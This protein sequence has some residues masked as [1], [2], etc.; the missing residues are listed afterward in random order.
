MN[1]EWKECNVCR[2][3]VYSDDEECCVCHSTLEGNTREPMPLA[4]WVVSG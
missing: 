3:L 2:A 1:K 4:E